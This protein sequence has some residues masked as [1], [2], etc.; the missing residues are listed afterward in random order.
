VKKR[1]ISIDRI[2]R[3][4]R[5][6]EEQLK[7]GTLSDFVFEWM[8]VHYVLNNEEWYEFCYILIIIVYVKQ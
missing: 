8:N 3:D 2:L 1:S 7:H 5:K 4:R 6:E